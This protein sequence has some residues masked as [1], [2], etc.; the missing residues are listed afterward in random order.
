MQCFP[1]N[2]GVRP[3]QADDED[4]E[5]RFVMSLS[6]TCGVERRLSGYWLLLEAAAR[7]ANDEV[8]AEYAACSRLLTDDIEEVL[9]LRTACRLRVMQESQRPP[10]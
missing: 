9:L 2:A 7:E 6:R 5:V 1:Q 10:W 4:A 8:I 3:H